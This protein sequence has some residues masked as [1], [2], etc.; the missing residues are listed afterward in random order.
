[1]ISALAAVFAGFLVYGVYVLQVRQIELQQTVRVV[2]PKDFIGAGTLITEQL[3]E[4]KPMI[5]AAYEPNMFTDLSQ[6]VNQETLVPLGK[7][8]PVLRWK[9]DKYQLLPS[10]DQATFQIPK[11][12]ILSI[13]NGIR[14][15]DKVRIYVSEQEGKS[16]RLFPNEVKVASVKSPS[17]IEV[18]DA[19]NS[20][21]LSKANDNREKMYVSRRFANGAIDQINLNLT[22]E[23]WL[24]I[25]RTC[26]ASTSK[27]VI[28]FASV[29][30]MEV[31]GENE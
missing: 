24:T 21:L 12:Y 6:V 8:E 13:S 10:V 5:L 18:D 11:D 26:K 29:S 16:R 25:D 22:E 14:A 30:I 15:G 20:N 19:E 27:L 17:N 7:E 2:V 28:A 1:M 31:K 9:V 3:I 23:E 4:Y